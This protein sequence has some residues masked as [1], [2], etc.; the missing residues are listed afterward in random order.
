[1]LAEDG[2]PCAVEGGDPSKSIG[3]CSPLVVST[4][5]REDLTGSECCDPGPARRCFLYA[6]S[7][8]YRGAL[9]PQRARRPKR[10]K[11][12]LS[13]HP[14]QRRTPKVAVLLDG[15]LLDATS[16]VTPNTTKICCRFLLL[17]PPL[18]PPDV[19]PCLSW[20]GCLGGPLHPLFAVAAQCDIL[21]RQTRISRCP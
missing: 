13:Q 9:S 3:C 21:M 5:A 20:R 15:V 4:H 7:V 17:P 10:S 6:F 16:M 14:D 8:A 1:M 12:R 2:G 19:L 18:R 11:L